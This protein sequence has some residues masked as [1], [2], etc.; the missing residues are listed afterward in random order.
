MILIC[1]RIL[2]YISSVDLI[3]CCYGFENN[4][5]LQFFSNNVY[6]IFHISYLKVSVD[7]QFTR[8]QSCVKLLECFVYLTYKY[9]EQNDLSRLTNT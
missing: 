5:S 7:M 1:L 2:T 4:A 3:D 8:S 9:A 6:V